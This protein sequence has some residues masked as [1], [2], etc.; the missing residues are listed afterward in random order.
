MEDVF[1]TSQVAEPRQLVGIS[2]QLFKETCYLG[3]EFKSHLFDLQ[4]DHVFVEFVAVV[5]ICG[6]LCVQV[7]PYHLER[8]TFSQL[9]G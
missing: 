3:L 4:F 6:F 5:F 9:S 2:V 8:A 7:E 1:D